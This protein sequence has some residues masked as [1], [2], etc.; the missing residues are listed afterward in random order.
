[1][2]SVEFTNVA[3][4]YPS[5]PDVMIFTDFNLK[6]PPGSTVAL[7]G[8]SGSGKFFGFFLFGGGGGLRGGGAL[9]MYT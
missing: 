7:V 6:V 1:M 5:Q 2:G 8:E 9:R 4:A 3:F